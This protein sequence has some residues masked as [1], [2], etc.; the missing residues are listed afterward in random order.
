MSALEVFESA[1]A[2]DSRWPFPTIGQSCVLVDTGEV[3]FWYGAHLGWCKPWNMPWGEV[4]RASI[5]AN[6]AINVLGAK[7]NRIA[8]LILTWVPTV[9]RQYDMIMDLGV[10]T[11]TNGDFIDVGI[12]LYSPDGSLFTTTQEEVTITD[13]GFASDPVRSVLHLPSNALIQWGQPYQVAVAANQ[14]GVTVPTSAF[15]VSNSN[16]IASLVIEDRG[17][18]AAPVYS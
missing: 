15:V 12:N 4:E 7:D 11:A 14:N 3:L 13:A 18:L 8:G 16:H 10:T 5:A 17:P 1:T 2:R 9:H 6:V